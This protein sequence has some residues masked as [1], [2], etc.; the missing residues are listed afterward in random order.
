LLKIGGSGLWALKIKYISSL[1]GG[2][3]S[4]SLQFLYPKKETGMREIIQDLNKATLA[5]ATGISY[6]RLRKFSTG[7]I[8]TLTPE[9]REKIYKYLLSIADKFKN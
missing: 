4:L 7:L 8:S 9:E 2:S 6:S 5:E 3:T 1:K